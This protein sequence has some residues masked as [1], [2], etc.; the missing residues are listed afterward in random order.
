MTED[1]NS[2]SEKTVDIYELEIAAYQQ[3]YGETF[4]LMWRLLGRWFDK[5]FEDLKRLKMTKP[6]NDE[7]YYLRCNTR[8]AGI[9][10]VFFANPKLQL[11]SELF[12]S[13]YLNKNQFSIIF[14][15]SGFRGTDHL[16]G[17]IVNVTEIQGSKLSFSIQNEQ[18]WLKFFLFYTI[19]SEIEID[20]IAF[21]KVKSPVALLGYLSMMDEVCV[22]NKQANERRN[23]LLE[24]GPSVVKGADLETIFQKEG[25]VKRIFVLLARLWMRCSYYD[26]ENKHE[27]K[28]YLN[29]ML[30]EWM[31]K[32]GVTE[33]A[34]SVQYV[35]KERPVI[36]LPIERFLSSHAM[37]RCYAPSIKQLREKFFLVLMT[38]PNEIDDVNR[39]LFDQ[40][41]E[42]DSDNPSDVRKLVGKVVKIKPDMIYYPSLGMSLWALFLA[43]L[44]L[45]PIQFM[46]GGHPATSHS[47]FIDYF[48]LP[49]IVFSREVDCFSEKV[50]LMNTAD[51]LQMIPPENDKQ[52]VPPQ[53]NKNPSP[54]RLIITS[55]SMK[56]NV[57]FVE[58]CKQIVSRSQKPV[59]VIFFLG[60]K[61][62]EFY[63]EKQRI[64]KWLPRA[65]IYPFTEYNKYIILLNTCDIH[66][67]PFPFGGTNSNVDSMKQ[68]IPMVSLEG[69]EPSSRTDS[70]FVKM[71]HLPDWLLTHSKE[72]Y[73]QAALRLIHNDEERVAISE[74][75]LKQDF[76]KLFRDHEYLYHEKVF[77][78]TVEWLY[79]YHSEIQKDGRKVWTVEAQE[80]LRSS[81][82]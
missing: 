17:A 28:K 14:E 49:D 22:L 20:Y 18:Q 70:L 77:L 35:K 64:L 11:E 81:M 60:T 26:H 72:E 32:K 42:L 30:Q 80:G 51:A 38:F 41:I 52:N 74:E 23:K 31:R 79:L 44:R 27:I 45:S 15:V 69:H 8:F 13:L 39:K 53:I 68:G 82:E 5:D 19:Y 43:N 34:F 66:L 12:Y 24:I 67:S 73:I 10:T 59:E 16:L 65:F 46:T 55:T 4:N 58:T 76:E 25:L 40:V 33:P 47:S 57:G 62:I 63:Q 48:L 21:F 36:L 71:S 7:E 3:R 9:I 37:Y 75:L 54:V 50:V 1:S 78:K 2:P 6:L 29:S 61:G 56:L